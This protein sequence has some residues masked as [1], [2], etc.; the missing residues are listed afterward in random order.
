MDD[1][2]VLV[3]RTVAGR[4][5]GGDGVA[6]PLF[7]ALLRPE[8]ERAHL[9]VEAVGA[10]DEIEGALAC[11]GEQNLDAIRPFVQ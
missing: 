3:A 7:E 4:L 2:G 10:D 8:S 6:E 1:V 5:E 11:A 9:R